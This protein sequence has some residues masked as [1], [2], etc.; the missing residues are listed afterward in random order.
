[1]FDACRVLVSM[2]IKGRLEM[3]GSE[4]HPRTI[5]HD[6]EKG[7]RLKVAE[8]ADRGPRFER[9]RHHPGLPEADTLP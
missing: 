6:I 1:M 8:F 2:G 7:A 3:R 4:L 9:Y 5:I